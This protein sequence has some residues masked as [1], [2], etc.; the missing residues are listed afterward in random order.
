MI[1]ARKFLLI[2]LLFT[3]IADAHQFLPTDAT[4]SVLSETEYGMVVEVDV[5][6]IVQTINGLEGEGDEL[7]EIVRTMPFP[8]ITAALNKAVEQLKQEIV[9]Y[10]D[11]VPQSLESLQI[12]SQQQVLLNLRRTSPNVE[13]RMQ[14]ISEGTVPENKDTVQVKFPD[15]LGPINLIVNSPKFLLVNE[16]ELSEPYSISGNAMQSGAGFSQVMVYL[17]QGIIHIIPQGLDHILFVIALFLLSTRI[18]SLLWQVTA[19]TLAHTITLL[20]ASYGLVSLPASIVE[21]LIAFS[22]VFVAVENI[23]HSKLQAWRIVLVFAFGLLHGLGFAS[24]LVDFGLPESQL[25]MSLISFNIG[26]EIGQLL[27]ILGCFLLVGWFRQYSW[28]RKSIIIPGS[29]MIAL[30]GLYWT[31][32]RVSEVL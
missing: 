13:Y 32:S 21:P 17:Y 1:I 4:L 25:I 22:I 26:V 24:V 30:T 19:F 10:F 29:A 23:F 3:P 31:I 15:Y 9:V 18:A 8:E 5:I 28:Y 12:T 27:V 14:L 11:E 7:I 16:G 2:L 6:E 20:M